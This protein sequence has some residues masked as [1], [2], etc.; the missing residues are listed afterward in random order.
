MN[1]EIK[2]AY[3]CLINKVWVLKYRE[4]SPGEIEIVSFNRNTPFSLEEMK[5]SEL[6]QIN[7]D[8]SRSILSV[9]FAPYDAFDGWAKNGKITRTCKV[10]NPKHVFDY[11]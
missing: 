3:Q 10:I 2:T 6:L 5:A 4:V 9:S 1:N 7:E 8:E 11:D